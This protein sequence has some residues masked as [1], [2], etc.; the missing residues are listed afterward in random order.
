MTV[1]TEAILSEY[2]SPQIA[3][4][5]AERLEAAR[6]A[7]RAKIRSALETALTAIFEGGQAAETA[8]AAEAEAPAPPK[9]RRTSK[10][11]AKAATEAPAAEAKTPRK[12]KPSG[13]R[14]LSSEASAKM[15]L[16]KSIYWALIRSYTKVKFT[17]KDRE[18]LKAHPD[19]VKESRPGAKEAA[20]K[21]L[22]A[23]AETPDAPAA[24]KPA[25]SKPPKG[26]TGS[27]ADSLGI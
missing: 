14:G 26:L 13:K 15:S 12:K 9:P 17:D 20:E 4:Q 21:K 3:K 7:E 22:A 23:K 27:R 11:K 5:V 1:E 8:A 6:A 2:L 16:R 18:L 24:A 19:L 25:N 10:A